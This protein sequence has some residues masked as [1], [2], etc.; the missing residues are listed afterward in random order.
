MADYF[1]SSS[2]SNTAPYD[3]WAKAATTLAAAIAAATTSGDK[4]IIQYDAVPSSD[5]EKTDNTAYTPAAN[6]SLISASNDGGSAYTLTA[7][8]TSSWLGNSTTA[9]YI[10]FSCISYRIYLYGVTLRTGGASGG[11]GIQITGDMPTVEAS[12]CYFWYGNTNTVT[13]HFGG[14]GDT[15]GG[16]ITLRDCTLRFGSTGAAI[17]V[18]ATRLILKNCTVS[19][20]GSVP[21]TLFASA[22][23]GVSVTAHGCDLSL[24]TGTLVGDHTQNSKTFYFSQ[25][26]L[27]SGVTPL[28]SQTRGLA[29]AEVYINDCASGDTHY[30]FGYYNGIGSVVAS[31]S[32]YLSDG[33]AYDGTNKHSWL[34][35]TTSNATPLTPFVTPWIS[36]YHDETSAVTPSFE[37]VRDGSA[38][39]YKDHEVWGE[40]SYKGT[41]GYVTATVVDDAATVTNRLTAGGSDQAT[42]SKGAGDWT[43]EGGTAWF[44]TL[45]PSSS[46]TPAEI[47]DI[48]GRICV[49]AA[50]VTAL[51]V[52]PQVRLA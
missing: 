33:A 22:Q 12:N 3:T 20:A 46:I 42:S 47:G 24:V 18:R 38:T 48:C 37:V 8:G 51:Y 9:R 16:S 4:V 45:A 32:I 39:A 21:S 26:K 13:F 29:G 6:I 7:M 40:W 17:A 49:G 50:S 28:A 35:T 23:P 14:G 41:S 19:S 27:G 44:G 43:G 30:S 5:A 11:A 36:R 34:I 31:A 15:R 2:G 1:V 52:D 10:T 25:C